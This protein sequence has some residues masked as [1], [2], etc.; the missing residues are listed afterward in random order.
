MLIRLRVT[1]L[2]CVV[3]ALVSVD[4][5]TPIPRIALELGE[6]FAGAGFELALVG[7]WVRDAVMRRGQADLD[8][9]TNATPEQVL[10]VVKGWAD[11][12]WDVGIR[13]GT[14]GVN[15][16]GAQLEITTYRAEQYEED[17]RKPTV[18]FGTSLDDDLA[19][20]DFTI[21][22]IALSLPSGE[23]HDPFGGISDIAAAVIKTP[24]APAD[25][26]SDDPLR[27][28]RACRFAAQLNFKVAD[29]VVAAMKEMASRIEIISA[30]RVRDELSK[31]LLAPNPRVGL[32]LLVE[33]GIAEIV[34]PEVPKLKLE[35]DEHHRHKDVFEH[36][37]IVLEQAIDLEQSHDPKLEP[38][39]IL[40]LAALL[41]DIGKP[42]TRR[43]EDGGGVSFHHHEV[44]GAKLAKK[45]MAALRF[46]NEEIDSVYR[47][48]ELHLRF[49]GYGN[50][51]WTDSAVRR[52]VRDAGD[53]LIRLHKLTR[54]DCTTRNKRKADNLAR[55]YDSLEQRINQLQLEEELNAIRP[56]LD[57]QQ[58]MNLLGIKP[59]PLVGKAYNYL[60]EL[61][62]D[63]GPMT[64]EQAT[65]EL[66]AWWQENK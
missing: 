5:Q 35:L 11:G 26:F 21:N 22:A 20:R 45:R 61:R 2:P 7:G 63:R 25:S 48:I 42:K 36:S 28:M 32:Q 34:L 6:R 47:L 54:A 17:S 29:E 1:A 46:S 38:D 58:I 60:L 30:E 51:E 15:K 43:F 62:L 8:F 4:S 52:Y 10:E 40:R 12:V 23:I 53:Q 3:S 33:T 66:L 39:L 65:Q 16:N 55:T 9:T 14:V 57:G 18:N 49:H 37:L 56:T 64:E 44:V 41:H 27:M 24:G 13:F 19:R 50:G 59:G 31:L